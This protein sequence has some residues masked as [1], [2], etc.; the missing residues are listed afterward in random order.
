MNNRAGSNPASPTND[1]HRMKPVPTIASIHDLLERFEAFAFDSYGVLVDGIDPLPGAI[2]L[3][4]HLRQSDVPFVVATNDASKLTTTRVATMRRQGFDVESDNVVTS[5]SLLRDWAQSHD[6]TGR[7][8]IATGMGEAVQYVKLASMDPV[9]LSPS[10][11][12]ASGLVIAGIQGYEW[13]TALSDIVTLLYRKIDAG[14]QFHG[15]VPNPDVLYPDGTERYAIGPGGLAGLIEQALE[16]GFGAKGAPWTFDRLG[17]P[18][19]PMFNE[20][21]A[22]LPNDAKVAFF[23][24]QLHTDIAG[25]NAA[26]FA[27]VLTGTGITRWNSPQDFSEVS[28]DMTPDFLLPSLDN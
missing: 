19:A 25:A 21:K 1:S 15:A 3:I 20:I 28:P 27:S 5:G 23:G 11:D 18:H 4:S 12:D 22:R 24:D 16:R 7:K 9:S 14:V 17:K 8:I 2:Q 6:L 26:G 10:E 13:E